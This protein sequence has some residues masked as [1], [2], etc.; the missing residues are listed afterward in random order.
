MCLAKLWAAL[1]GVLSV[2]AGFAN[3]QGLDASDFNGERVNSA[4]AAAQ[5]LAHVSFAQA[6]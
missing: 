1:E 3:K 2:N 4:P 5:G 6:K